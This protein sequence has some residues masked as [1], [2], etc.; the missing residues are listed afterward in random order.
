MG[1]PIIDYASPASRASLRLPA[2]SVIRWDNAPGVLRIT[3]VLAGRGEAIGAL[4]LAGFTFVI[5]SFSIH[6]MIEKWHRYVVE[7]GIMSAFMLAEVIVGTLVVNN[8]WRKTILRVTPED[9]TLEFTSPLGARQR[10]VFRGEQVAGVSVVDR[11]GGPGEAV[12]PQLEIRLWSM[13]SVEL[14][15]G[16]P[17]TT[18]MSIAR[19]IGQM[20]PQPPPPLP[21]GAG[22]EV[23]EAVTPAI[24]TAAPATPIPLTPAPVAPPPTPLSPAPPPVSPQPLTGFTVNM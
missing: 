3:Q 4:A 12:V 9:M 20:Q 6:G 5:M 17:R 24:A 22:A 13:P 2:R 19:A 15:A 8:T 21:T 18:L 11:L 23:A 16:H 1:T 10:F 7:I 14:F